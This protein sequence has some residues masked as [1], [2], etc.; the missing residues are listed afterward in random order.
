MTNRSALQDE[1]VAVDGASREPSGDDRRP[2][3]GAAATHGPSASGPE[4]SRSGPTGHPP[5]GPTPSLAVTAAV[6]VTSSLTIMANA[7]IAPSLPGLA[8]AF[9]DTP[10]IVAL[11][12]LALSL[13]SLTIVLSAGLF[14]WLI[15]RVEPLRV[16]IAALAL[17]AVAGVSGAL[18]PSI[19]FLLG[20]RLLL[21]IG[22]AGTMT[23]ATMLAGTLWQGAAR[24]RIM[25]WQF[26]ATSGAG[27]LILLGGG[28]L[29][30]LDWRAPFLVYLVALPVALFAAFALRGALPPR[31]SGTD[32]V[33]PGAF[34]WRVFAGIGGLAGFTMAMFYLIPTSLPFRLREI[35]IDAPSAAGLAIAAVTLAGI[36]G[37]L[38]F[39]RIR[40]R[41]GP[42]TI[43]ALCFALVAA[44]F[45]VIAAAGS[46]ALTV[47]G[48]FLVG[49]GLG[50]SFP[51]FT[52]WLMAA[53]PADARGRASG[54][55]TVAVFGG[56][57][58][59]PVVGGAVA[60]RLGLGPTFDAF[61]ALLALVAVLMFALG[62]RRRAR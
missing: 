22:V 44:G 36:P 24:E 18:A 57:F 51:N 33:A 41:L 38:A 46:L 39:G 14:G 47:L 9:A 15:D 54:L 2:P 43:T 17:Y 49:L 13:P 55:F 8:D 29:A 26:A 16:L 5:A 59:S 35:G 40:A 23:V 25:G 3:D 30:E 1:G 4:P 12:A 52:A 19:E 37:S 21:G 42:E 62:R 58:L 56:Q 27:I 32:R 53:V 6:L 10:N 28:F 50:P 34:P 31:A 61:A 45:V 48:T 20:G 60:A 11:S 7:T